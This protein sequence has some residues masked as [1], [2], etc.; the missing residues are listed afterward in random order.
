MIGC[1]ICRHPALVMVRFCGIFSDTWTRSPS[2]NRHSI[3]RHRP[4]L[5]R[6]R[7][8]VEVTLVMDRKRR[9]TGSQVV[10]SPSR[11]KCWPPRFRRIIVMLRG[12]VWLTTLTTLTQTAT[13]VPVFP[14]SSVSRTYIRCKN[15]PRSTVILWRVFHIS[16]EP[17]PYTFESTEQ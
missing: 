8:W 13:T 16:T 5:L 17:V 14:H 4:A 2:S 12:D 6:Y 9:R 3:F 15:I 10:C 7:N 11:Q 1:F